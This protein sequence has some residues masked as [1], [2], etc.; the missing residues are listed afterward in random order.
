MLLPLIADVNTVIGQFYYE[1]CEAELEDANY[2]LFG[3]PLA[4]ADAYIKQLHAPRVINRALRRFER[5]TP[6]WD[7]LF[8]DAL[9]AG[10]CTY[11]FNPCRQREV[12]IEIRYGYGR[13]CCRGYGWTVCT[14]TNCHHEWITDIKAI[15]IP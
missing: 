9:E 14:V 6:D 7:K 2:T 11:A 8:K 15:R 5:E 13:G 1:L 3:K 12:A 4:F 10:I